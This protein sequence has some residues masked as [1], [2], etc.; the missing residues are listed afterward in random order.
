MKRD[1][2]TCFTLLIFNFL[3]ALTPLLAQQ[4]S[5]N[6]T[7]IVYL[8]GGSVLRGKIMEQTS[9]G[10]FVIATWSGVEMTFPTVNV[11]K[12][13]QKCKEEKR[14]PKTYD[15]KEKGLY[16][17]TRLGTLIGQ[18]YFGE[19]STGFTLHHTI[20]WMFN[21]WVGAGIGGGTEI[22]NPDSGEPATYPVFAEVRGYLQAK[23]ATPFYAL[24]GGWAFA[25]KNS[26]DE[27]GRIDDW[28]GGWLA[29]A[30][31]GYRLG[32]HFTLHGG[33]SFQKKTRTWDSTWGGERG[34]DRILNKRLEL[35][36]GVI[37]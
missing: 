35:G 31:I 22:Y 19:N 4:N 14:P 10:Y 3:F 26:S 25:G 23:N 11:R 2:K 27:W 28:K 20:G 13:V 24:C 15:F 5:D 36:L 37:L 1:M 9:D 16:N 29:K 17:A 34:T 7:D 12:V 33:I 32:N 18:T 8:K 6:C 30:Q 21:R